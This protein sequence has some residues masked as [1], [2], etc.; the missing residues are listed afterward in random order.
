MK[1]CGRDPV[2]LLALRGP[3]LWAAVLLA[4]VL[5]PAVLHRRA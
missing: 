5:Q 2:Q 3:V 4:A 1:H